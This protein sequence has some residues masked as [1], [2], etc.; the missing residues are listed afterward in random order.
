MYT[1]YISF[2]IEE[3]MGGMR[4]GPEKVAEETQ[5]TH[6]NIY[7]C[8]ISLV[9]DQGFWWALPVAHYVSRFSLED[10]HRRSG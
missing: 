4:V 7:F 8:A 9:L 5:E 10:S 1:L 2:R 6:D 3:P